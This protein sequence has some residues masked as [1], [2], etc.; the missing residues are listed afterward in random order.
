M[1]FSIS[2]FHNNPNSIFLL[3]LRH[4]FLFETGSWLELFLKNGRGLLVYEGV[5][6]ILLQ[7]FFL[8]I[9]EVLIFV[10]LHWIEFRPF[11]HIE[12]IIRI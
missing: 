8:D 6:E 2:L 10:N 12:R 1:H 11:Y 4:K 9:L 5:A 3:D 7:L